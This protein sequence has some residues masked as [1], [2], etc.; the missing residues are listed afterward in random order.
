MK[1]LLPVFACVIIFCGVADA[2][3]L[4]AE[5]VRVMINKEIFLPKS[6]LYVRFVSLIEDSRCPT[7][8]TCVWAGNAKIT[9]RVSRNGNVKAIILNTNPKEPVAGFG[10]YSI[11]LVRLTPEPRSNIRI[12]RNRYQATLEIARLSRG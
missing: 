3:S 10:G 8:T 9:V 2:R 1:T 4:S 7:D 11:K 6:K 5:T 12:D